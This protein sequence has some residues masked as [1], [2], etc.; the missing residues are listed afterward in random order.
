MVVFFDPLHATAAENANS[1]GGAFLL[2][3]GDDLPG[4]SVAELLAQ[5]FLVVGD[6]MLL[7]EAD[8]VPRGETGQG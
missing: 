4:A 8:E 2:K 5:F 3:Q 1:G 6:P 7:H